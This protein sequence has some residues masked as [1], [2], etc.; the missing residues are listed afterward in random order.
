M[1]SGWTLS[2]Q[3]NPITINYYTHS[4]S[5]LHA[6]VCVGSCFFFLGHY[7]D[8][9]TGHYYLNMLRSKD[10]LLGNMYCGKHYRNVVENEV[11]AAVR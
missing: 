7:F 10:K 5:C 11:V 3:Y 6:F 4:V 9:L 1:T 2:S 8:L